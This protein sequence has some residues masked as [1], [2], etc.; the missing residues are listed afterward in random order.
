[1]NLHLYDIKHI[2]SIQLLHTK[3]LSPKDEA[4]A[5]ISRSNLNIYA[6]MK[7]ASEFIT[8]IP[9]PIEK[10]LKKTVEKIHE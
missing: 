2:G 6:M 4:E 5:S 9:D 7:A 3:D 8:R 1:M 10:S